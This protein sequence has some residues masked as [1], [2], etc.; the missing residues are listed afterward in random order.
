[1]NI[2]EFAHTIFAIAGIAVI[3]IGSRRLKLYLRTAFC[4]VTKEESHV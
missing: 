1:M 2:P 4:C 3:L